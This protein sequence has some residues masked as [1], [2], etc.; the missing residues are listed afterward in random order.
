M[1]IRSL[2]KLKQMLVG[3]MALSFLFSCTDEREITNTG[4]GGKDALVTFALQMPGTSSPSTRSATTRSL[5]ATDENHVKEIDVL[6]FEKNGGEYVYKASCGESSIKTDE[7]NSRLKTFTVTLRQGQYDLVVLANSREIIGAASLDG[8]TKTQALATLKASM[9]SGGKWVASASATGYKPFPMWGDVGTI[10]VNAQTDLTGSNKILLTRAVAR[11]DVLVPELVTNFKLTSVDVYNYNTQGSLVP[12]GDNWD[13]TTKPEAPFATAPNVPS[14]STLTEGPVEYNN[15]DSKTEIN[16][17]GNNCASE[18]YIFEAENHTDAGHTTAKGLT[19]RTCLVIGGVWDANS[20]GDLTNDG[21]PTYYRVDFSTGSGVSQ[22]FID[23]KRNHKYTFNINRV[24]GPGYEDSHTAFTSGPV[25]IEAAVVPWNDGEGGEVYFDSQYY[26][27]IKPKTAFEFYKEGTTQTTTVTTDVPAGWKITKITEADGMTTNSGWLETNISSGSSGIATGLN[28]TVEPN[29][30]SERT[31]Y[32][33]ITAGRI[34]AVLTVT[35]SATPQVEPVITAVLQS[36]GTSAEIAH[37]GGSHTINVTSNVASWE[38]VLYKNGSAHPLTGGDVTL[39]HTAGAGDANVTFAL[40][41]NNSGMPVN[42][43]IHF[44]DVNNAAQSPPIIITHKYLPGMGGGG[45]PPTA[46]VP[47]VANILA[48]NNLGQLNL[49][50]QKYVDDPEY[51][52]ITSNYLVYF[53]WGSVVAVG[54]GSGVSG[55]K[56]ESGD[57]AWVPAVFATNI[58]TITTWKKILHQSSGNTIVD[59]AA[60]GTGDPC[61]LAVRN[62]VVGGY[63]MPSGNPWFETIKSGTGTGTGGWYTLN[64]IKGRYNGDLTQ[65]YPAAGNINGFDTGILTNIGIAG[66]YWSSTAAST[67]VDMAHDLYITEPTAALLGALPRVHAFPIR[68]IP[69]E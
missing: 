58:S 62:G 11:V 34:E 42:Y 7:G 29:T 15:K 4:T 6:V 64:G 31:G 61:S 47:A 48:V 56:F 59:D 28:I 55:G 54:A 5:S 27:S 43:I 1:K 13:T 12:D 38:P 65:F 9:P 25:N 17:A 50:G 67:N 60:A 10:T 16:T 52:E 23:V 51:P 49:D 14:S 69:A 45:T 53:K 3:A 66:Y 30:G 32:I 24:S 8:L 21:D 35:Q 26:L 37:S 68:C 20:D 46:G 39:S 44:K 36:G 18:I 57:I 41:E 33:F 22:S 63:K 19:D 40:G 2:S